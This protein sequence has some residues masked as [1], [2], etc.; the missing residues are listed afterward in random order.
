MIEQTQQNCLQNE[1]LVPG[2][3]DNDVIIVNSD[4]DKNKETSIIKIEEMTPPSS[5]QIDESN[6][7]LP[8][9]STT[10]GQITNI[11]D[12]RDTTKTIQSAIAT[13]ELTQNVADGSTTTIQSSSATSELIQNVNVDDA[14]INDSNL[15]Q[16][17][18]NRTLNIKKTNL[19]DVGVSTQDIMDIVEETQHLSDS[20]TQLIKKDNPRKVRV[21]SVVDVTPSACVGNDGISNLQQTSS[22]TIQVTKVLHDAETLTIGN[23]FSNN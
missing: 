18:D 15:V 16:E 3:S 23:A 13:S 11:N 20:N 21:M 4:C 22:S 2:D 7:S 17:I 8:M 14:V 9:E 12:D 5:Q 6:T 1:V 10:T 19:K